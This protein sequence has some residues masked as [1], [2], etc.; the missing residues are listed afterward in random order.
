MTRKTLLVTSLVLLVGTAGLWAWSYSFFA[1]RFV[2]VPV[3]SN[4]VWVS[5]AWGAVTFDIGPPGWRDVGQASALADDGA[6]FDVR[7]IWGGRVWMVRVSLAIPTIVLAALVLAVFGL[8]R[9]RR[10][11]RAKR[12]QCLRCGYD[13]TGNVSGVCPE[14]GAAVAAAPTSA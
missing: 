1:H 12:S 8:P 4:R 11:L 7:R 6:A 10:R 9:L 14:C 5:F 3:G 2:E 13:L